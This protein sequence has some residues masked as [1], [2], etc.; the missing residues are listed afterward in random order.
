MKY[1][2]RAH[3][4]IALIKYWGKR[5]KILNLPMN[6]SVSIT[7]DTLHTTTTI[8]PDDKLI[9]DIVVLNNQELSSSSIQ[10]Q[11]IVEHLNL[12]RQPGSP[13]AIITSKNNF[14][15]GSGLASSSSGFAALTKAAAE[16]YG[17]DLDKK[18]LSIIA[19][20]GSG[21]ASRSLFGGF[22]EWSKGKKKDGSDSFANQLFPASHWPE[23]S[24]LVCIV[25]PKEKKISSRVGME[26]TVQTSPFYQG[27]L[28]TIEQ[29]LENMRKAIQTKDFEL[30]GKTAE[31]NCLKMHA[32]MH[33]TE[34]SNIYWK[35]ETIKVIQCVQTLRSSGIPCYFTMDA[36][37]QV[38]VLCLDTHKKAVD[39]QLQLIDGIK[40][41]ISCKVI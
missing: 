39:E 41:I 25:D 27:W 24:L 23:L 33:T 36:G 18:E 19:R 4:N 12:I 13:K 38:K 6:S 16:A 3:A 31:H 2:A 11:R 8:E 5:D 32:T 35:P 28:D 14:P 17:L 9:K 29:D 15:T 7:L 40:S 34:P 22:V 30:L 20:Q 10:Y 1:T 21:S 37:P 26:Q